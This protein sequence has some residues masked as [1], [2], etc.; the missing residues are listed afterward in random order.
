VN[1]IP[2]PDSHRLKVTPTTRA[3]TSPHSVVPIILPVLSTCF[4]T[5]GIYFLVN[6]YSPFGFF[7]KFGQT[8]RFN[9]EREWAVFLMRDT[10]EKKLVF[11]MIKSTFFLFSWVI[12]TKIN[13]IRISWRIEIRR[14]FFLSY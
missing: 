2:R 1:G 3:T 6:F 12:M 10:R 14:R 9:K 13:E 5:K 11:R 4:R 8:V 7:K